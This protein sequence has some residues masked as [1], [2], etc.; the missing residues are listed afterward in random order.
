LEVGQLRPAEDEVPAQLRIVSFNVHYG[1]DITVLA[2]SILQAPNLK[3]SQI[4]LLQEIESYPSEEASRTRKL[5]EALEMNYAYAP[6]RH[7]EDSDGTHG[8]AILSRYPLRDVEI[9]PLPVF[10]LGY[11]TRRRIAVAATVDVPGRPLRVYNLHLDTRINTQDR[12]TQLGPVLEAATSH[13]VTDTVIGGDFNTNPLRWLFHRV[14]V[15]RSN[16]AGAVDKLM[17]ENG[18]STPLTKS[19]VTMNRKLFKARVDTIYTRGLEERS[20]G[21]A[22]EVQSSDHFPVWVEVSWPTPADLPEEE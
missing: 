14:P 21:V 19:G 3:D 5:A 10:D 7:I 8:L 16:Q 20:A 1:Q 11:R 6:A 22:R 12:L 18:F 15:F 4:F 2:E 9:L 13:Q 17:R